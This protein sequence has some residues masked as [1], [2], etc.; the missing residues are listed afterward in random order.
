M[1]IYKNHSNSER[2]HLQ[3]YVFSHHLGSQN[4]AENSISLDSFPT[5][6]SQY[7]SQHSSTFHNVL[8]H[9]VLI[10]DQ[11]MMQLL[12]HT[13]KS[14]VCKNQS[15]PNSHKFVSILIFV[16]PYSLYNWLFYQI[17]NHF[18]SQL[19]NLKE[20][21]FPFPVSS[22]SPPLASLSQ[23]LNTFRPIL[24]NVASKQGVLSPIFLR[25]LF[26]LCHWHR[27]LHFIPSLFFNPLQSD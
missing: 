24:S 21:F 12:L 10:H 22:A 15:S 27:S 2:I 7:L 4:Y 14:F 16:S 8:I 19:R 13:D 17:K 6:C 1:I 26:F 11:H 9:P 23:C 18:Y 5:N 20:H 3:I 25:N